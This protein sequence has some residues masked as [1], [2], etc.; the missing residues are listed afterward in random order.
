M[1]ESSYPRF[2]SVVLHRFLF[3][4][5]PYHHK[6]LWNSYEHRRCLGDLIFQLEG[7]VPHP[8]ALFAKG[9]TSQIRTP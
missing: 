3:C 8:F 4:G 2:D 5:F 6:R 9:G 1:P 7:R